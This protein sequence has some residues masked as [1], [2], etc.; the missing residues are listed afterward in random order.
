MEMLGLD[1]DA[2]R[3]LQTMSL[4]RLGPRNYGKYLKHQA[5]KLP[6]FKDGVAA[7]ELRCRTELAERLQVSA[8]MSVLCL[9]AR[10][11]GEVKAFID[12]GCFAV[13][14]DLNP[15]EGN[16]YVVHG[17]FH[18]VQF[19]NDSVDV[20]FTNSVDHVFDLDKFIAEICRVLKPHG[21]LIMDIAK[22]REA[23]H[24]PGPWESL[25]WQSADDILA[26]FLASQFTALYRRDFEWPWPGQH[27]TLR[28]KE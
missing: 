2:H 23:S 20:I 11:G 5:S 4:E 28:R 25:W 18:Q 15:G 26:P 6:L 7:N 12:R 8:G 14:L 22:G 24:P 17:D 16:Q 3:V 10:L 1:N 27:V 13:G 9:G 21:L 19:A